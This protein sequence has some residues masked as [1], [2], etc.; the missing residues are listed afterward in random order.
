[1]TANF[2]VNDTTDEMSN[3]SWKRI[4]VKKVEL[5]SESTILRITKIICWNLFLPLMFQMKS[6]INLS[7]GWIF[8]PS[9]A[10][11]ITCCLL[12]IIFHISS[13]HQINQRYKW[14]FELWWCLRASLIHSSP[15]YLSFPTLLTNAK[16]YSLTP[17][18]KLSFPKLTQMS[19]HTL[20]C[21]ESQ[22]SR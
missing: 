17:S 14:P 22:S 13:H 4:A 6:P 9:L 12:S 20:L 1:M 18:P 2:Y 19:S 8:V 5:M 3:W 16:F 10:Q 21:R 11:F 7:L 15:Y